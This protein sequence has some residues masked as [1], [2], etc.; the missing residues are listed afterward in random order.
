MMFPYLLLALASLLIVTSIMF[1]YEVGRR[2][3]AYEV[4]RNHRHPNYRVI[5]HGGRNK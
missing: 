5:N 4:Q 2:V 3:G 1:A